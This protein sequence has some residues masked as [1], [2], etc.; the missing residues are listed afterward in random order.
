[1]EDKEHVCTLPK[2]LCALAECGD[3]IAHIAKF[4]NEKD[5]HCLRS[6][7]SCNR[8][9]CAM[10][11]RYDGLEYRSH[12]RR[13]EIEYSPRMVASDILLER[14]KVHMK[15][16]RKKGDSRNEEQFRVGQQVVVVYDD[17]NS[18]KNVWRR[19]KRYSPSELVGKIGYVMG[20]SNKK[21]YVAFGNLWRGDAGDVDRKIFF[22]SCVK[23]VDEKGRL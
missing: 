20:T 1:M 15:A 6:L 12:P 10:R 4:F 22:N 2:G 8:E 23:K 3:A 13:K 7:F 5:K 14:L 16:I 19:Y 18:H 21:V 17:R 9:L 11:G